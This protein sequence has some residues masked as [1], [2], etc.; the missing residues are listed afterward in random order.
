ME[1]FAA[2]RQRMQA[3][4][5]DTAGVDRERQIELHVHAAEK[6]STRLRIAFAAQTRALARCSAV[7]DTIL[8]ATSLRDGGLAAIA[9]LDSSPEDSVIVANANATLRAAQRSEGLASDASVDKDL[10]LAERARNLASAIMKL[11]LLGAEEKTIKFVNALQLAG[12]FVR[13][14]G[15]VGVAAA[16][17]AA[18]ATARTAPMEIGD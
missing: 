15:T 11:R 16:S 10:A 9:G 3:M 6:A 17:A 8:R 13:P 7:H 14:N 2:S 5:A 18:S 4:L 12:F 1:H